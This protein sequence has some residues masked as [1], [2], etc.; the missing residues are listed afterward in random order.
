MEDEFGGRMLRGGGGE[1]W[2]GGC[3]CS[4]PVS[5]GDGVKCDRTQT[6]TLL[7]STMR[8]RNTLITAC[9]LPCSPSHTQ[10]QPVPL[11]RS[12][13]EFKQRRAL[14]DLSL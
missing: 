8:L 12:R 5:W 10:P 9:F 11:V 13:V 6:R 7:I 4:A 1:K 14:R 3:R 2:E